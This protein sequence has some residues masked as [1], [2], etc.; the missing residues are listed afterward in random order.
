MKRLNI[1]YRIGVNK[2]PVE[3]KKV[4]LGYKFKFSS[5]NG[6]SEEQVMQ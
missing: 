1:Q 2:P 5:N 6:K 4:P 3:T